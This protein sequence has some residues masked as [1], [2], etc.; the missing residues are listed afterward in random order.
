MQKKKK[1]EKA[2]QPDTDEA[3]KHMPGAAGQS[4]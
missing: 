2:M 1:K 3:L 4:L